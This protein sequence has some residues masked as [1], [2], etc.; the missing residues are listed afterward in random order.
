MTAWSDLVTTAL[1]GTDRRE[2]PADFPEDLASFAARLTSDDAAGRLLDLA[3]GYTAYTRAGAVAAS[4]P[5]PSQAP[6]IT[7]QPA[8]ASAQEV[9]HLLVERRSATLVTEWLAVCVDHG[10]SVA[11]SLWTELADLAASGPGVDVALL[12]LALGRRGLWFLSH[13]DRWLRLVTAEV[14]AV[15]AARGGADGDSGAAAEPGV[16]GTPLAAGT[17]DRDLARSELDAS[18][19][20]SRAEAKVALLRAVAPHLVADDEPVLLRALRDRSAEVRET[21]AG[22]ICRLP[23]SGYGR[24]MAGRAVAAIRLTRALGRWRLAVTP[25]A[26]DDSMAQDGISDKPPRSFAGGPAAFVLRQ[27]LGATDLAVWTADSKLAPA[28]L[29]EVAAKAT[30]EWVSDLRAGWVVAAVRQADPEWALALLSA[31]EVDERLVALVPTQERVTVAARWAERGVD[32]ARTV[33]LVL[34]CPRPWA[35]ELARTALGLFS[36]G[37]PPSRQLAEA[38]G[39]ALSLDSYRLLEDHVLSWV[40]SKGMQPY[41][42]AQVRAGHA[43]IEDLLATRIAIRNGFTDQPVTVRRFAVP[44]LR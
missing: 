17:S 14:G 37:R 39:H 26:L 34:A 23:E 16:V 38:L 28:E 35:G 3:A 31:G 18:W 25:P 11:P 5:P 8:P 44:H 27:I 29:L 32:P 33:E 43:L 42:A 1:L 21:A 13:N 19:G 40:P 6:P 15:K 36:S 4:C 24:R 12:R 7:H 9:L 22:M 30:P 41:D 10:L 20:R 2:I